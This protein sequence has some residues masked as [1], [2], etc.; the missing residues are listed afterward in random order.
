[1]N[2][3]GAGKDVSEVLSPESAASDPKL[4]LPSTT[5]PPGP[6]NPPKQLVWVVSFPRSCRSA[7]R[8]TD[9]SVRSSERQD[10]RAGRSS[11]LP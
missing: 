3:D 2:E 7:S 9:G 5:D 8:V 4:R 6:Q 10:I 1:M 11:T